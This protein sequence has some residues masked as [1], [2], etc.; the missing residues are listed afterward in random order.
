MDLNRRQV[1]ALG[2]ALGLSAGAMALSSYQ[3]HKPLSCD[4]FNAADY[5]RMPVLGLATST[6]GEHDYLPDISG[7]IPAGLQGRLYRNGPGLFERAG[8][9]K[10]CLLDGDGMV[11]AF[12]FANDRVHYRNRFVRTAKY[13]A[14]TDAGQFLYP[15]WTTQAPGGFW[16]NLVLGNYPNQA[17]ITVIHRDDRLFAFDEYKFPYEL[18]PI[19]LET[20]GES[21]LGLDSLPTVV[22]AH[23]KIDPASGEWIFFGVHYAREAT[24]H[25]TIIDAT[26]RLQHH[27]S[28]PLP[29]YTYLHDFF[30]TEHYILINLPPVE[31]DLVNL[32]SGRRSML[33]SLDWRPE[34]GNQVLVLE[35]RGNGSYQR[36][37]A[38]SAWM[39]HSLNAYETKSGQLIADFI[40]YT[41][42]DHLLGRDPALLAIMDG[43]AGDFKNPGQL[44]RYH[45]DLNANRLTEER[46]DQG[47]CEFPYVDQ[48]LIGR[49]HRYGYLAEVRRND[50][51]YN[52]ITRLDCTTGKRTT[53]DFGPG[54]YCS[55]PIYVAD[56]SAA[57]AASEE[58]GWLLVAGHD[59]HKQKGFLGI[60]DSRAIAEGPVAMVNL[61]HRVPLSFHGCW[62]HLA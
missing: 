45:I 13:Q 9:R 17:G 20:L 21:R 36:F 34:S 54:R 44:R 10:R 6:P 33:G 26:G 53:F 60:F 22:S 39:W 46:I 29:R 55:E 16:R 52:S 7:Q 2:G 35:R 18:D 32:L 5:R 28:I 19:T 23:S 50:I 37:M 38:E 58:T 14:E 27:Q 3:G 56:R 51:F 4:G 30:I 59:G 48:R 8:Q 41:Y 12:T 43:R 31:I 11:Q 62:N 24:L 61:E 25:L 42:P 40:G 15:S 47:N 1:L 57:G 49:R